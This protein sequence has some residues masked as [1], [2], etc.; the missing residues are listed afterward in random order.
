MT[1]QQP[2]ARGTEADFEATQDLTQE[3]AARYGD[4]AIVQSDGTHLI[5]NEHSVS[6]DNP[7]RVSD[8]GVD[9]W[10]D[11]RTQKGPGPADPQDAD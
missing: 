3:E 4:E 2:I 11:P 9:Q 6:H 5:I 10:T 8:S 1:K 7:E